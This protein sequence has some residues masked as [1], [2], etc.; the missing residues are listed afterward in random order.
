VEETEFTNLREVD[1]L[2]SKRLGV[3][4]VLGCSGKFHIKGLFD[5]TMLSGFAYQRVSLCGYLNS[6]PVKSCSA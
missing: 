5:G 4:G 1:G 6:N 3:D 2:D